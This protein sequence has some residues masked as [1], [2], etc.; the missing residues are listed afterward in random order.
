[1][2]DAGAGLGGIRGGQALSEAGFGGTGRICTHGCFTL[3]GAF[4][5]SGLR[6]NDGGGWIPAL[7]GMTERGVWRVADGLDSV[8]P[9]RGA[10]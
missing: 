2:E 9:D 1:L 4:L 5:D 8:G 7:A 6:R 3:P 10:A